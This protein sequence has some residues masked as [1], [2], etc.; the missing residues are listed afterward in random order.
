MY[1]DSNVDDQVGKSSW[2]YLY[3]ERDDE[4]DGRTHTVRRE[5]PSEVHI[6]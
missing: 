4:L 6:S 3:A 5:R 1:A 2:F